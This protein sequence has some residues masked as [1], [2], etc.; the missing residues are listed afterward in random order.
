MRRLPVFQWFSYFGMF[1]SDNVEAHAAHGRMAS[2]IIRR[3]R[4]RLVFQR[5]GTERSGKAPA[6]CTIGNL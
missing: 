6:C 1:V 3:L 5:V 4:L 2:T